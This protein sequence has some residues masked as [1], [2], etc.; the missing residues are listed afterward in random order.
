M[1]LNDL[2]TTFESIASGIAGI[3][4]FAFDNPSQINSGTGEDLPLL[5][6]EPPDSTVAKINSPE[7]VMTFNIWVYDSHYEDSNETLAEV[8]SRCRDL[9][10]SFLREIRKQ[11]L[12]DLKVIEPVTIIRGR[13]LNN[14]WLVGCKFSFKL[15]MFTDCG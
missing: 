8:W 14:D 11:K 1:N 2:I 6:V 4:A 12:P 5:Y 10:M 13:N 3:N 9:G 15:E 7:E